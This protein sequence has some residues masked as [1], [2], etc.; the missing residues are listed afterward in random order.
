[1]WPLRLRSGHFWCRG[2]MIP[3]CL[4]R[5]ALQRVVTLTVTRLL[6]NVAEARRDAPRGTWGVGEPQRRCCTDP[7]KAGDAPRSTWGVRPERR[8]TRFGWRL[9]VLGGWSHARAR[10]VR[11]GYTFTRR[12][13]LHIDCRFCVYYT[14][15]RQGFA[16]RE[17]FRP[18]FSDFGAPTVRLAWI[19]RK[20]GPNCPV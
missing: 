3:R 13:F 4:L 19:F 18:R 14:F 8:R 9:H 17:S 7:A 10:T 2:G 20:W 6:Q 12:A 15:T 11:G 1:M 16:G 5:I